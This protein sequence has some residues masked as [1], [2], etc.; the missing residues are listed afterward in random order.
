[1]SKQERKTCWL[2]IDYS[3]RDALTKVDDA[4]HMGCF[5]D[6]ERNTLT[7]LDALLRNAV[8]ISKSGDRR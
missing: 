6:E 5:S 4:L 8:K 7:E 3:I 1:M 2:R